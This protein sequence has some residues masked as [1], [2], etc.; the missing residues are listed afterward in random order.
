MIISTLIALMLCNYFEN[1]VFT[2]LQDKNLFLVGFGFICYF[3]VAVL[4]FFRITENYVTAVLMYS[5]IGFVYLVGMDFIFD[6]FLIVDFAF[7]GYFIGNIGVD[8]LVI[9]S[10]VACAIFTTLCGILFRIMYNLDY[11]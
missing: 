8:P 5:L 10:Y 4:D 9:N 1:F 3:N 11:E 2:T 6:T 7:P